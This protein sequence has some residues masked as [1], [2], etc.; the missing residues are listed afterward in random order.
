MHFADSLTHLT[1]MESKRSTLN[2]WA[3]ELE[4][5]ASKKVTNHGPIIGTAVDEDVAKCM[6]QRMAAGLTCDDTVL[7]EAV[8]I[9][10]D[11]KGMSNLLRENGGQYTFGKN[12]C[13]RFWKR[14][15]Y[16]SRVATTKMR[17]LPDDYAEKVADYINVAT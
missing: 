6:A 5:K 7:R 9:V 16:A 12:W 17:E 13:H 11:K 10:L 1:T 14:H 3:K 8:M 2:R 4:R 15:G